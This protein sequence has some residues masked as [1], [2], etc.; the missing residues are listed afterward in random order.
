MLYFGYVL[1]RY[2]LIYNLE[3]SFN[4]HLTFPQLNVIV[5]CAVK[6]VFYLTLGYFL[7]TPDNLNLF[8][9]SLEGSSYRESTVHTIGSIWQKYQFWSSQRSECSLRLNL[10]SP[11]ASFGQSVGWMTPSHKKDLATGLFFPWKFKEEWGP[12]LSTQRCWETGKGNDIRMKKPTKLRGYY[13]LFCWWRMTFHPF[14][15]VLSWLG[16]CSCQMIGTTG[17]I[18]HSRL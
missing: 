14:V 9:I 16:S 11:S 3:V 6:T 18:T 17:L 1:L 7:R 5:H 13:T 4:F 2:V 15:F 12:D 8:S 10:I